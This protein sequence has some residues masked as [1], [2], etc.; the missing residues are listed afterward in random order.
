MFYYNGDKYDG[1]WYKDKRQG[2]GVYTYANGAQYKGQWMNDM[3]NGNGFFNWGDGTTYDGQWLDN[4]RSGKVLSNMLMAMC[5]SATG[6]MISRTERVSIN[7]IMATFMKAIMCREN[8]R[9]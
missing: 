9:V 6:R 8:A 3:K 5:I 2:R 7:F 4:Q 1:D